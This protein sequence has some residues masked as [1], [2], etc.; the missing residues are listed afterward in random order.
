MRSKK[1][2]IVET[3]HR[4]HE[5]LYALKNYNWIRTN[6]QA[7][8]NMLIFMV[9]NTKGF[10][11]G[12]MVDRFKGIISTYAWCKQQNINFRI[13]H[14]FPFDLSDFLAPAEYDWRL[15][16]HEY[17]TCF[18]DASLMRARGE[19]GQRLVKKKH[20]NK[21]IHYY[22]NR[23]FLEYIN[24]TGATNYSWGG[25]FKE[26]FKPSRALNEIIDENIA[27]IGK[28]YITAVFRFQNLLGDFKEY[29][30]PVLTDT[31]EK[32][33]LIRQCI[34]GLDSLHNKYPDTT[35]LVTS[36]SSFFIA[37]V[38]SMDYVHTIGGTRVHI[39]WTADADHNTYMNSFVDF[40]MLANSKKIF[41]LGTKE[42]YPTEFP[43]YAAKVNEI[44]F[45]RILL[46]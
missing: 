36:D 22:G 6:K 5:Y 17:T 2:F 37:H 35:I 33:F 34:K 41:S 4:I 12:G 42:M 16:N 7:C 19:Y 25:L 39:G 23:D 10:Y 18:W 27:K 15:K 43:L 30:Y 8:T 20:I 14:I 28:P 21:Q 3:S 9:T 32:T 13:R 11:V 29:N 26:L 44:P 40:Y 46:A 1:Q 24:Q 45:E 38:S 31:D